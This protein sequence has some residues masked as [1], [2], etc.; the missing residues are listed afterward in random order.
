MRLRLQ[1]GTPSLLSHPT[2]LLN[3]ILT[4]IPEV[5]R[6]PAKLYCKD[7]NARRHEV[8]E[9]SLQSIYHMEHRKNIRLNWRELSS[10]PELA[11][12]SLCD[13][14]QVTQVSLGL[15]LL[16]SKFYIHIKKIPYSV[17]VCIQQMFIFLK[18]FLKRLENTLCFLMWYYLGLA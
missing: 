17:L 3:G 2:L 8:S 11:V 18:Y 10:H 4:W 1:S 13:L 7:V 9:P 5:M 12:N 14:T 16:S 15:R 6:G